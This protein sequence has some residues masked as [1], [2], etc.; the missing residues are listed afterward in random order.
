[1]L[2]IGNV[3]GHGFDQ[4]Q[5]SNIEKLG[6]K[7][8]PQV[9]RYAGSQTCRFID[10]ECG[11]SLELI[12]VENQKKYL[13]FLPRGMK[14]YCPGV[15]LVLPTRP[16]STLEHY[17]E[18]FSNLR[19]YTLHFGYDGSTEQGKPG[20]NYLNFET[21]IVQDTFIWLTKL[22][23][24]IPKK[25]KILNHTNRTK[26]ILGLIFNLEPNA[27]Q[28][29]SALL[30]N[31]AKKDTLS[32]DGVKIWSKKILDKLPR[33]TTKLFPLHAIVLETDGAGFDYLKKVDAVKQISFNNQPALRIETNRLS[34]D[35]FVTATEK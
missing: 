26:K 4:V 10:F 33:K 8:S 1:M 24:P 34:W 15:N 31:E 14:A 3:Y 17:E 19:P 23:T 27:L 11:P 35:I 20:W 18:K 22:E 25:T 21:P 30:K 16:K 13:D 6:F 12:E 28:E 5:L 9:S 32:I 29:L 2:R 7:L